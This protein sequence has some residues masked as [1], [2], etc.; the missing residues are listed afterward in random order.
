MTNNTISVNGAMPDLTRRNLI[1]EGTG[2]SAAACP[3]Q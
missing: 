2:G 3:S 1:D